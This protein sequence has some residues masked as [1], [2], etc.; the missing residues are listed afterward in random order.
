MNGSGVPGAGR[1][2]LVE[3]DPI[4][5]RFTTHVL[6]NRGGF[7][8]SHAAEPAEALALAKAETW[9]LVLTDVEIGAAGALGR[10]RSEDGYERCRA[11]GPAA[12]RAAAGP[13]V[14]AGV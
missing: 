2:L 12:G 7:E 6:T 9:D 5:A 13:G 1:I 8:V 10:A 3:D 11:A 4:T 14:P